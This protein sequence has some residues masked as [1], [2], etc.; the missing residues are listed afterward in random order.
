MCKIGD[1]I[2]VNNYKH[3]DMLLNRHSFIVIDDQNGTIE[4]MPYDMIC[5]VLSS[6]KNE[7][8]RANKLSYPGNF[9]IAHDDTATNPHNNKNGYVKADQLYYFKKE[10]ISY[11]VIGSVNADIFKLLIEFINDSDFEIIDVIDNL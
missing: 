2:L 10:N 5:N 7:A 3:G 4:G 8:Q 1:I 9:P 6:F 11:Q